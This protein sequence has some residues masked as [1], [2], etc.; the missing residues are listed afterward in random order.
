MSGIMPAIDWPGLL[1]VPE[2]AADALRA[3]GRKTNTQAG[4]DSHCGSLVSALMA[5]GRPCFL[6]TQDG[7]T[8]CTILTSTHNRA[9][10]SGKPDVTSSKAQ[11]GS[12]ETPGKNEDEAKQEETPDIRSS[13]DLFARFKKK[14]KSNLN[15]AANS[16]KAKRKGDK[17]A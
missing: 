4:M 15:H 11:G 13:K 3:A 9:E 7:V 10:E 8:A 14:L 1:V 16:G 5:A 12:A 6:Q 2:D 17:H